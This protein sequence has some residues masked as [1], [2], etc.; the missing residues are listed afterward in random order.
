VQ[1][2]SNKISPILQDRPPTR[3]KLFILFLLFG[4]A[5]ISVGLFQSNLVVAIASEIILAAVFLSASIYLK[6]RPRFEKC[7]QVFFAFFV[8]AV[9]IIFRTAATASVSLYAGGPSSFVAQS[10]TAIMDAF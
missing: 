10:L 4:I 7:W 2:P 6:K 8:S 9:V 1:P 5:T 3:Y